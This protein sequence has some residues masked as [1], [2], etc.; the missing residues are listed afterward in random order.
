MAKSVPLGKQ[1]SSRVASGAITRKQAQE[2]AR[3]RQTFKA[4]FGPDWRTHV[5]GQG[6]AKGVEG[7]FSI[8]QIRTD[9]SQALQ[10]A[11]AKRKKKA[12]P[13]A[14]SKIVGNRPYLVPGPLVPAPDLPG[15]PKDLKIR[16]L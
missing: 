9:R 4:M 13:V 14:A 3:Q 8:A 6:G 5:F 12:K 15:I 7:P 16:G 11:R 2:T 1:L 10:K